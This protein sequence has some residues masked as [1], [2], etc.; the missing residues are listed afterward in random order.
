V[1]TGIIDRIAGSSTVGYSGNG[2]P[3]TAA[4]MDTP[5]RVVVDS[6][7][8]FYIADT[9]NSVIR[10]VSAG[11]YITTIAGT[12]IAGYS[13]D[14]GDATLAQL[15]LPVGVGFKEGSPGVLYIADTVN[16]RI[17]DMDVR[18]SWT[19]I[20]WQEVEPQ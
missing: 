20:S 3:A 6:T 18:T 19:I 13:G 5:A 2:G 17:R 10:R 8:K 14:G 15:N 9:G 7:G 4:D 16:H 12:G 1:A 11:G